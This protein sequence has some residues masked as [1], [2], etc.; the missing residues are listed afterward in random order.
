M[1]RIVTSQYTDIATNASTLPATLKKNINE[2]LDKIGKQ[3]WPE[4]P[5]Q[6]ITEGLKTFGVELVDED[7]TPFQGI[8]TGEKGRTNIELLWRLTPV[9][10]SVL[11]MTWYKMSSGNY[12]IVAYLG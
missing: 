7:G 9:R 3:Y 5:I 11:T 8:F 4:V 6:E 10:N 12:E 2:F 1:K